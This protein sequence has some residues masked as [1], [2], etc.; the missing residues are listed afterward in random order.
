MSTYLESLKAMSAEQ[1]AKASA[2][3]TE[4]SKQS[5]NRWAE[6]LTPLEDRLARLLS[7]MPEEITAKGL[8]LNDLRRLLSGKWRGN[9]HPGE[10]GAALRKLGYVR[11]RNWAS[12]EV[13][14]SA[15]WFQRK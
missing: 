6:R 15:K 12:L 9:C 8:A 3:K 11:K 13:G 5:I 10:L 1:S 4:Q 2:A 7:T 14:F